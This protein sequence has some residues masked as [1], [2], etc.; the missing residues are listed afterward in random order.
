MTLLVMDTS[1][2]SG[3]LALADLNDGGAV[4]AAKVFEGR[5]TLSRRLLAE[6]N[7]L[8]A[9][10]GM[11]LDDVTAFGVGI[12]PG[13]FTGVRVGVTTAKT[14]AQVTGRPLVG[15]PTLDAYVWGWGPVAPARVVILPSRRGEVYVAVYGPGEAGA[16]PF[17][18]PTGALERRLEALAAQ[19]LVACL[20]RVDLLGR[21]P[22]LSLTHT[23]VPP[24]GLARLAARRLRDGRTDDPLALTPL[25]VV[26]PAISTP[27]E[28]PA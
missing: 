27:K 23:H 10:E 5:R 9:G 19:G 24:E 7:G 17:A 16:E 21:R 12:G 1:G 28:R 11:T 20:G 13:S 3:V 8:L 4:R 2:D 26:P 6:V 22:P 14:L 18:E 25:Y 15:V